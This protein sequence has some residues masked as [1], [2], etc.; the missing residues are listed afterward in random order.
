MMA[1][2]PKL[3]MIA[4]WRRPGMTSRRSSSRLP[5]ESACWS[6]R[7]VALPPGFERLATSPV[8]TGSPAAAKTMGMADVACLAAMTTAQDKLGRD[9]SGALGAALRPAILDRYGMAL[10]PA[11]FAQPRHELAIPHGARGQGQSTAPDP[12]QGRAVSD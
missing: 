11:E 3:P 10:K 8:P 12:A 5:A 1:E 9:F 2:L 6:E 7:P 4:R